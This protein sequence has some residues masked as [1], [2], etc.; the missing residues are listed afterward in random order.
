MEST[1]RDTLL[2]NYKKLLEENISLKN[3]LKGYKEEKIPPTPKEEKETFEDAIE[4]GDLEAIKRF[5][6]NGLN[7]HY[8]NDYGLRW[9]ARYGHW[10]LVNYF[11]SKV[12]FSGI[13]QF[14]HQ[15]LQLA[16][17]AGHLEI[18][19]LLINY[20]ADACANDSYALQ[21]AASCGHFEV[22]KVLCEAWEAEPPCAEGALLPQSGANIYAENCIA[23][24]I[25][26]CNGYLNIVKYIF[27]K[28]DIKKFKDFNKIIKL[29][30]DVAANNGHLKIIKYIINIAG[31][32]REQIFLKPKIFQDAMQAAIENKHRLIVYY[33][34]ENGVDPAY[35]DD[36]HIMRLYKN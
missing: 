31:E 22:V 33:L 36:P 29:V 23:L 14:N 15:A 16:A 8:K 30:V 4:I 26:A 27:E 21:L 25:A 6:E 19:Q 13:K 12:G 18:V 20:G 35:C 3:Q 7:P 11:I 1:T 24:K 32:R 17:H 5:V 28:L 2:E 34:I 9:A 10:D